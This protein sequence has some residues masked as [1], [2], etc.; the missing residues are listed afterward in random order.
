[1]QRIKTSSVNHDLK[2]V[3]AVF[4]QCKLW[5]WT[6]NN[7]VPGIKRPR[8]PKHCDR[9]ISEEEIERILDALGFDGET[10]T[11]QRHAT[12]VAFIFALQTAMR[13]SEIWGLDW[14]DVP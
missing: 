2:H 7:P 10:I 6:K 8:N 3:S 4:E 9:R 14:S 1:M 13:Q 12:A 11:E 5:Q